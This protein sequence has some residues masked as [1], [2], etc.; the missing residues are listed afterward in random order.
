MSDPMLLDRRDP[1]GLAG[2]VWTVTRWRERGDRGR[3]AELRRLRTGAT[4]GEAFFSLADQMGASHRYEEFLRRYL[5]IVAMTPHRPGM[6]AGTAMRDAGVAPARFERW[7]RAPT[8]RAV[9][10]AA[11]LVRRC[12]AVDLVRLGYQLQRWNDDDRLAL[13]REYHRP[14]RPATVP[15]TNTTAAS[16]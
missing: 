1:D 4:P 10:D 9:E 7:L 12:S 15:T 5:P 2:I 11:S 13:A 3:L 14:G 16:E 6:R 8:E